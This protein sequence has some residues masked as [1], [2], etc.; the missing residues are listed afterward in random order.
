MD[1]GGIREK[2]A[3]LSREA[4]LVIA[5]RVALRTMPLIVLERDNESDAGKSLS[6]E[7]YFWK[8]AE[9]SQQL[10]VLFKAQ[11]VVAIAVE[12]EN[13]ELT[14]LRKCHRDVRMAIP[15]S[16]PYA[17]PYL[18]TDSIAQAVFAADPKAYAVD[19]VSNVAYA[20]GHA[21]KSRFVAVTKEL[22]TAQE[23]AQ[24]AFVELEKCHQ[25]AGEV[26]VE[27]FEELNHVEGAIA[28][29]S[30]ENSDGVAI[31]YLI[32]AKTQAINRLR[33]NVETLSEAKAAVEK[34]IKVR[35]SVFTVCKI[36]REYATAVEELFMRQLQSDINALT[37][38][39]PRQLLF[40]A[41][42]E[43]I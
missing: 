1:S 12:E 36:A 8:E 22:E 21:V 43:C 38:L 40:T 28:A 18:I 4:C 23:L 24:A 10:L 13:I 35:D 32:N 37:I 41:T 34:A 27:V 11:G 29:F 5:S 33:A 26:Q 3:G 19:S 9:R 7:F 16:G 17:L 14:M 30:K 39:S 31:R 20:V 2:L 15:S 6:K 42:L 25:D